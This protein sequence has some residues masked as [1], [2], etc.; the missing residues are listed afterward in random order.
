MVMMMRET[1]HAL[2]KP[3]MPSS[4]FFTFRLQASQSMET[5]RVMVC[6]ETNIKRVM[7]SSHQREC[8]EMEERK[9]YER[10]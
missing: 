2:Y 6:K 8:R 3:A 1:V 4:A 10:S 5:L 7:V 9:K